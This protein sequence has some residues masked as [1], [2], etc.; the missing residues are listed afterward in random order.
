MT[1]QTAKLKDDALHGT[2]KYGC[3]IRKA[4]ATSAASSQSAVNGL[5]LD[6]LINYHY[7]Q[8]L[9]GS[10][11]IDL[12]SHVRRV[13]ARHVVRPR[14]IDHPHDVDRLSLSSRDRVRRAHAI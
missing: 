11:L 1:R 9:A 13:R 14:D 4:S 6:Y 10:S 12:V 7:L 3:S 2:L 5:K 8:Q